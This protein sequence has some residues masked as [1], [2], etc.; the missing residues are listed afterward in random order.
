MPEL[1]PF[2]SPFQSSQDPKC[3]WQLP[4]K[5]CPGR[6]RARVSGQAPSRTP[7]CAL[8]NLI[9]YLANNTIECANEQHFLLQL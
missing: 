5:W 2:L 9:G 7:S 3:C 6:A 1:L 8:G 4:Q